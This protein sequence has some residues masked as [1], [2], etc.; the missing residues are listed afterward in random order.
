MGR[1]TNAHIWAKEVLDR[2]RT[3]WTP[4]VR[5]RSGKHDRT[6]YR[7]QKITFA[8]AILERR[9]D[10]LVPDV[11]L[12][13][14]D[15]REMLVEVHVTHRCGLEKIAK[16]RSLELTT[17]EVD[18]SALRKCQ[19]RSAIEAA[20]VEHAPRQWLW[21]KKLEELQAQVEAADAEDR[22]QAAERDRKRKERAA[23]LAEDAERKLSR[24]VYRIIAAGRNQPSERSMFDPLEVADLIGDKTDERI[25][26]PV[27]GPGF[28][29]GPLFWQAAIV[30]RLLRISDVRTFVPPHFTVHEVV[31]TIA[32][33]IHP[34]FRQP[35]PKE[36]RTEVKA[37]N[38]RFCF[39]DETI[40]AYLQELCNL[41]EI[42]GTGWGY[43][44]GEDIQI[45]IEREKTR[46]QEVD[47]RRGIVDSLI[48]EIVDALNPREY[49]DFDVSIWRVTPIEP[50]L[51]TPSAIIEAGGPAWDVFERQLRAIRAMVDGEEPATPSLGLP[52]EGAN[53]R[54]AARRDARLDRE[55]ARR[56]EEIRVQAHHQLGGDAEAWL[57]AQKDSQ[58]P[59]LEL[60]ARDAGGLASAREA[61]ANEVANRDRKAREAK[62]TGDLRS[63]LQD[64]AMRRLQPKY[65][66]VFLNSTNPELGMSPLARCTDDL[67]FS[68]ALACLNKVAAGRSRR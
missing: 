62:R 61:L 29:V 6:R 31:E 50:A 68:L 63:M 42:E 2:T 25:R 9:S 10:N 14:D 17:V 22:T 32:D 37:R 18:L 21:N 49:V 41:G 11:V 59:P 33:C 20:L 44:L 67:G 12:V 38:P 5:A 4:C 46:L 15:G 8:K 45:R 51:Q 55:K 26:L 56:L 28:L 57:V 24:E 60:A 27:D 3:I 19:N 54:A 7:P 1:E 52:I 48:D 43:A 23:L 13:L 53:H 66:E 58:L 34:A 39:P 30:H 47:Y 35:V 64:V 65:V 16:I 36:I 40:E